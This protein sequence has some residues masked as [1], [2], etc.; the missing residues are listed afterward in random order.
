MAY[1]IGAIISL[2]SLFA[3][4]SIGALWAYGKTVKCKECGLLRVC[5]RCGKISL[6]A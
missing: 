3:G 2:F 6:I 1:L 5:P 4:C